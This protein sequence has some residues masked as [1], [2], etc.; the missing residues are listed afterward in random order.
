MSK[1]RK[2]LTMKYIL[3][4]GPK[5]A[6]VTFQSHERDQA[7]AALDEAGPAAHLYRT[8]GENGIERYEAN[9]V[10]LSVLEAGAL[11]WKVEQCI[12]W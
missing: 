3:D 8:D 7:F 11:P 5:K 9:G 4:P 6:V 2:H 10:F 12:A 1:P